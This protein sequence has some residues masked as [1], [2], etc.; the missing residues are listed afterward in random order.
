M[1]IV[2]AGAK[3]APGTK[4]ADVN[5]MRDFGYALYVEGSATKSDGRSCLPETPTEVSFA[6]GLRAGSGRTPW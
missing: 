4:D 1:P 3:A 6:W 2:K 5:F